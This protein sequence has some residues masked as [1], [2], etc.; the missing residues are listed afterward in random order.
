M[1]RLINIY[2]GELSKI[3]DKK[4]VDTKK[5]LLRYLTDY[6][7]DLTDF[8]RSELI[9]FYEYLKGKN[10]KESTLTVRQFYRWLRQRG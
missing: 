6:T 5:Y 3:R 1:D 10:L 2:I 9:R 4:T 7:Y 8:D